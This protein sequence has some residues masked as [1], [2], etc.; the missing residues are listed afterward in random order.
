ML[1][2][3][4]APVL[5]LVVPIAIVGSRWG[6]WSGLGLAIVAAALVVAPIWMRTQTGIVGYLSQATAFVTVAMLAGAL[7]QRSDRSGEPAAN[8]EARVVAPRSRAEEVL[9][10]RELEVL[11]M[12]AEGAWNS[13]IADRLVIAETTVQSHVQHILRKLGVRNRTEAAA[14]YLRG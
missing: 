10:R 3:A 12:I 14:R 8:A 5:I 7:H 2:P 13:E 4:N 9:S 11:A 1:S 6:L